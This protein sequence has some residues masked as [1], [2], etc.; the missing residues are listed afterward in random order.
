MKSTR[1]SGL[2]VAWLAVWAVSSGGAAGANPS[3]SPAPVALGRLEPFWRYSAALGPMLESGYPLIEIPGHLLRGDFPYRKRPFPKE[4]P[5][6]DH[7]SV[8]RLLGGYAEGHEQGR[9]GPTAS[10]RDLA[11]R[12]A[13]GKVRYRMELLRPR[14]Q[15]YLDQGYTN[16]TLV[17]DNVPWCFPAKPGVGT[18]GQSAPPRDPK[19]WGEFVKTLC[20]ELAVIMG[21]EAARQLRF[22]VGTENNGRERFN[23]TQEEFFRHYDFT[24][25]AVQEVL[26]G[27]KVGPFNISGASV[28]GIAELANVNAFALAEHCLQ[29]ANLANG[30]RPTP[31]D[32]VAFSRYY[33]PG[34]DPET[35]ARACRQVW[36]EFER[37]VPQLQGVSREIHE[38][39]V[40]P[41]GEV[42]KGQFVSAE[43]GALGAA[44]TCQMMWRLREAGLNRL[45][46]WPVYDSFRGRKAELRHL[47]T[48][49]AW[50]L[51]VL[52]YMA[53]GDA[54]LFPP[55]DRSPSGTKHLAAGSIQG[56][57]ALF[58]ISACHTDLAKHAA[59]TVRFRVP[60]ELLRLEGRAVRFV[61]LTPQ[62]AVHDRLRRDFA[63]AGLLEKDFVSRPDRLGTVREMGTGRAAEILAGD[64]WEDLEKQW[65]DSL[66]LSPLTEAIGRI[67]SDARGH[68]ISVRLTAPEVLVISVR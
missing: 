22:R 18:Y 11:Y 56:G 64:H 34:D 51:S 37:R 17:L 39:G 62:T 67:E 61:Q 31:F 49:Q 14:L 13:D 50:V 7:L 28:R 30:R 32:W 20:R 1:A 26:P 33:R 48:G 45:W 3:P 2:F 35:H 9:S 25:A 43:P 54:Y 40:A 63:A 41:F 21:P 10:E 15:P 29:Q 60:A 42:A 19:E 52:D 4:V 44:L 36:E 47:F 12:G 55:L 59:E 24:A 16:L 58:M 65:G 53:G 38:F 5:F 66:T 8:V 6:A 27:A 57:G 68:T 23:G 46:H